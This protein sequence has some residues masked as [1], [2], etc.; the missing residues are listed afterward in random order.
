MI[1]RSPNHLRIL[2]ST[3]FVVLALIV[4][5]PDAGGRK[6]SGK[7][8][9]KTEQTTRRTSSDVKKEKQRTDQEIAKTRKKLTDNE[10]R[11]RDQLDRL[12]SLNN[13]I[14]RQEATI[15][16][17][18]ATISEISKKT[19]ALTDTIAT[20]SANDSAL[21]AQVARS[22]RLQSV[23]RQ[24][25]SPLAFVM[26]ANTYNETV[27][28]YYYLQRLNRAHN[29]CIRRL[30][31]SR[32]ELDRKRA[33]LDSLQQRHNIAL[34][35]LTTANAVL[36]TRR[37]E[38]SQTVQKLKSE[39]ATLNR[40]LAEQRRRSQQL[41]SE[42]DRIIRR[43]QQQNTPAK[44]KPKP[45]QSTKPDRTQSGVADADRPLTGSFESNKG[46]MLFPVAGKYTI[47]SNFG[48]SQHDNLDHIQVENSGI[49]IQVAAGTA[50]RAVFAGTVTSVFF[51]EGYENIVIIRHGSYLTVYAGLG[52]INVAK[53]DN[54]TTGQ[55]IGSVAT[56][57]GRTVLHF[58]V[59]RE[60]TKLNPLQW[61]K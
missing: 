40:V 30:R 38:S 33:S 54:V 12:N 5:A 26:S 32:A 56:I 53:G 45:G 49:D 51:M 24:Q 4:A 23:R 29:D 59:R 48:R 37:R 13:Q 1:M 19:A 11:T 47:V 9:A 52:K 15:A 43:E 46:R 61:V 41:D 8:K 34:E 60:R 2:A 42:L 36:D 39:S 57:D 20:L 14:Q 44:P 21:T 28:R 27:R 7:K 55:T 31:Q 17:L 25:M 6:K 35:Q 3:L 18:T 10:R 22:L 50:V 58:E 16:D